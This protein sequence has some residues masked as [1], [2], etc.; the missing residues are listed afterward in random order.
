MKNYEKAREVLKDKDTQT[1]RQV[2]RQTNTDRQPGRWKKILAGKQT[3]RQ[4]NIVSIFMCFW[5]DAD[6]CK[7]Y[8]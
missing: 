3:N 5:F 2:G 1:E 6:E 7:V 8:F 4:A